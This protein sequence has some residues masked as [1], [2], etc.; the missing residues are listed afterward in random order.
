MAQDHH[1]GSA[2]TGT[3]VVITPGADDPH[4]IAC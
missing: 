4:A 1:V 3:A 2:R